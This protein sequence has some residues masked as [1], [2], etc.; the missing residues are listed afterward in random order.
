MA[1]EVKHSYDAGDIQVLEGL[2]PVRKRPGMYIGSTDVRGLHHLVTEVVDNSIDEALA[3]YCT[4]IV[5]EILKDGAIRVTDNGRGI[6]TGIIEKEGK[7][8][9]EVVLTKL[10]AG[11][12]FG[13]GGYK[14]SGGLHGVGVSCVNAL[15][16][17]L[18][19]EV[20]QNG[21]LYRIRF[22]RGIAERP[23][24]VVGEASDT[25]TTV[26]FYPDAEIFET[27]EFNYDTM[28]TRLRELA[29]LN[30]GLT[31]E[32]ADERIEP[33]RREVFR[34]DGGIVSFV[35]EM[36]KTKET[37]FPEVIY[38]DEKYVDSE[39]EVAMQYNDSYS[40]TILAF[41]NNINTEE[42]GTHLDGFKAS[43]T[44]IIN[45]YGSKAGI[46]KGSEK[47]SGED[48]R[49]G[50]TAV[51]SVKLAEPQFEGQTKTKLGNS[52]MRQAVAKGVAEGFGTYLE[53]H[54]RE[55]KELVLKTI[56]AQRAREAARMARESARRKSALESTT[57]PGK[58]AD[59]TDK[60][61]KNCEIYLVEGD[62]AGGS[63][64]QGRD[65]RF[66]AIL[67][68]RGKILN[69]EKAALHRVLENEEIKAMITAFGCGIN[70]EY[71]ESKLRYNRII[72]MTDADVDGS[73]IRILMLTFLFRFMRPLIENGH[74][75]IAL[76]PL[77]KIAKGKQ[78]QYFYDDESL[79]AYYNEFGRKSGE[80]QRYKG[81]GEMNP[82]QLWETTMDPQ[83]RTLL[84]VTME[85]AIEADKLFSILMGEQPELRR[86]FIEQNAKLVTDLDV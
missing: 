49:E 7:S 47:L 83:K 77:Y 41:A 25:G 26:T 12:K 9:V 66:Q 86:E 53:E 8:A 59:C 29:Y 74:V 37:I 71:D 79:E 44:K 36:N 14:I 70:A 22:N 45:D 28:K 64:K 80:L 19:A 76:P 3:G 46:L 69:V 85:D 21:K 16:E 31:I 65:R 61:P 81:L 43:L 17:W 84:K 75:F 78:E 55:A 18:V 56:T 5:V 10:H 62:S 57:L 48:V 30:K 6:P 32:L 38:F 63:A 82:E 35:E 42:G 50:L 58:L 39:I 20:R 13:S 34:Y 67:P 60:D 11:G 51:I 73:H 1:E 68:L 15:S 72:C 4:H 54:P 40:D 33:E 2:D 27:L 52:S 23:L 24:A